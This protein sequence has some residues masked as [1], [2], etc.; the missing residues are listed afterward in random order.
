MKQKSILILL[1]DLFKFLNKKR[2]LQIFLIFFLA[3]FSAFAELITIGSLI[4]FVDLMLEPKRL[5]NYPLLEN[6]FSFIEINNLEDI[7]IF[8]TIIFIFL[9]IV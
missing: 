3:I 6:L 2:K 9:I 4:P 8:M 5:F 1:L 7:M